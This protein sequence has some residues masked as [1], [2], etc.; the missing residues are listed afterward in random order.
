MTPKEHAIFELQADIKFR[1]VGGPVLVEDTCLSFD[2]WNE[3]PGPYMYV[4]I[5]LFPPLLS[6]LASSLS[7]RCLLPFLFLFLP[8]SSSLFFLSLL[9]QDVPP[10]P[11][12]CSRPPHSTPRSQTNTSTTNSKWF[13]KEVGPDGMHKLLVGFEDKSAQAICTFAYCEGPGKE[14]ISTLR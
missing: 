8:H 6:L 14:P 11:A 4:C 10:S 3:L 2:A 5:S 12:P 13:L 7:S 9:G 1:Q